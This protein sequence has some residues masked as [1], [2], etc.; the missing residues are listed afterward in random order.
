[1]DSPI[2]TLEMDGRD[3]LL[4]VGR[5]SPGDLAGVRVGLEGNCTSFLFLL[6]FLQARQ[7]RQNF[8]FLKYRNLVLNTRPNIEKFNC[9]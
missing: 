9:I 3:R 4:R 8:F 7:F 6:C 1:M 5:A 2:R